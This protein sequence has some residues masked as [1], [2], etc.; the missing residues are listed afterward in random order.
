MFKI[1]PAIDLRG[2]RCVRLEQGD[3]DRQT[4]YNA[5]PVDMARTWQKEGAELIHIVDL[6]GAKGGKPCHLELIDRITSAVDTA[7]ELGGG[8]R[9]FDDVC[10]CLDAGISRVILGTAI[11]ENPELTTRLL[12]ELDPAKIVAGLDARDGMVSVRGWRS[13]SSTDVIELAVQL[14]AQGVTNFIY[15]DISTDGM[16]TGPNLPSV[17]AMCEACPD[18][19]IVAS[20]GVGKPEHVRMLV[21]LG[22]DNLEGVIVGKALYDGK[23]TFAELDAETR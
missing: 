7:C 18:A 17:R 1:V 11:I 23:V 5:D 22:L 3:Y 15:T 8:I 20:G 21:D 12:G 14:A 2:G 9:Q 10:A 4:T 6:D 13:D 19:G 16:F